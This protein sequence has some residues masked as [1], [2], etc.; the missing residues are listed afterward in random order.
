MLNDFFVLMKQELM[1]AFI[2]FLLLIIKIGKDRNPAGLLN[3]VNVLL[4]FNFAAGFF[5]NREGSLFNDMFRT[6]TLVVLQKIC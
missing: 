5:F 6:N 1:I 2:I 4:A 3:L